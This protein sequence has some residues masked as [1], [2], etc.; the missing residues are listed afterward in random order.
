MADIEIKFSSTQMSWLENVLN[1]D[2][3]L[4]VRIHAGGG[5][6]P[7]QEQRQERGAG[8]SPIQMNI[9]TSGGPERGG[10]QEC[11]SGEESAGTAWD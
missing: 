6:Q 9:D 3:K 2:T 7:R 5:E 10:P 11:P 1:V 4:I 8:D